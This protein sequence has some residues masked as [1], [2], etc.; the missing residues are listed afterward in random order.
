MTQ[1]HA[2]DVRAR[3]ALPPAARE[4]F[5]RREC[6]TD[7]LQS[8]MLV[9]DV[10]GEERGEPRFRSLDHQ[11]VIG[12]LHGGPH[13]NALVQ[14]REIDTLVGRRRATLDAK[15]DRAKERR[16]GRVVRERRRGSGEKIV[17]IGVA[18]DR[19]GR[20]PS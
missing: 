19:H 13:D 15:R 18:N 6:A 10:V 7:A 14:R 4:R 2:H 8:G 11:P 16:R 17:R 12:A 20:A 5:A 1:V 9:R 3:R